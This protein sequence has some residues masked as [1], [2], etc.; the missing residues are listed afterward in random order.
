MTPPMQKGKEPPFYEMGAMPFQELCRDLIAVQA[1]FIDCRIYGDNGEEQKGI[2]V[3]CDRTG[4]DLE[5]AQAKCY[6][7]YSPSEIAKASDK[8]FEYLDYWLAEGVKEFILIV[9]CRISSIKANEQIEIERQRFAQHGIEYELWDAIRIRDILREQH[10]L[11]STHITNAEYWTQEICGAS[12]IPPYSRQGTFG[13]SQINEYLVAKVNNLSSLINSRI[14]GELEENRILWREGRGSNVIEWIKKVKNNSHEW[15]E[16]SPDLQA[17]IIRLEA[18]VNID[19]YENY[20][21][22]QQ[23]IEDAKKIDPD[24]FDLRIR[25]S[26]ELHEH[27]PEAALKIIGDSQDIDSICLRAS[28]HLQLNQIT[29]AISLLEPLLNMQNAEVHRL[30]ALGYLGSNSLEKAVNEIQKAKLIDGRLESIQI[31]DA[32]LLYFSALSP[33][34]LSKTFF[35]WPIPV[36]LDLIKSS[37]DAIQGLEKASE[38]FLRIAQNEHRTKSDRL[39]LFVWYAACLAA[40]FRKQAEAET[41]FRDLLDK[42][43]TDHRLITWIVSR[44]FSANLQK[45][46][47]ELKN[48]SKKGLANTAHLISAVM[49]DIHMRHTRNTLYLLENNK[50]VF[51]EEFSEHLWEHWYIETLIVKN[52][53]VEAEERL[54]ESL[55]QIELEPLKILLLQKQSRITGIDQ[56]FL[57]F[58]LDCVSDG[59]HPLYLL[60]LCNYYAYRQNW[61]QIVEYSVRLVSDIQTCAALKLAAFSLF[62]TGKFQDCKDFI[63]RQRMLCFER[64]LP[65]DLNL[66]YIQSMALIGEFQEALADLRQLTE[67]NPTAQNLVLLRNFYI[68]KGDQAGLRYVA[69][70]AKEAKIKPDDIM[71]FASSVL[72]SSRELAKE[73]WRLAPTD[74]LSPP[75]L[76]EKMMLGIALGLDHEIKDIN[77]LLPDIVGKKG[78]PLQ[79]VTQEE[80]VEII[81]DQNRQKDELFQKYSSGEIPIHVLAKSAGFNLFAFYKNVIRHNSDSSVLASQK[82]PLYVRYGG[83]PSFT[84]YKE[85]DSTFDIDQ[86]SFDITTLLL[87]DHFSLLETLETAVE[88]I[89]IPSGT[90]VALVQMKDELERYQP[91]LVRACKLVS[92]YL[93]EGKIAVIA[94]QPVIKN[95][96][97]SESERLLEFLAGIGNA[98]GFVIGFGS[99]QTAWLGLEQRPDSLNFA[100]C[101][102]LVEN[103]RKN[104][105]ITESE[106][107]A[108]IDRLGSEG[109]YST[110]V[111]IPS[112]SSLYF[113][114]NTITQIA[115][116]ELMRQICNDY[117]IW[118]ENNELLSIRASIKD[119]RDRDGFG[120]K[121][122]TLTDHVSRGLDSKKY[123][124]LPYSKTESN[125]EN[126][127]RNDL[128]LQNLIESINSAQEPK[129]YP[130]VDDLVIQ[131]HLHIRGTQILGIFDLAWWFHKR[132]IISEE[133]YFDLLNDLRRAELRYIPVSSD[134]ILLSLREAKIENRELIEGTK[135]RSLRMSFSA[136]LL[137]GKK[138]QTPLGPFETIESL[139]EFEYLLSMVHGVSQAIIK[140][141]EE[142]IPIEQ[143]IIK[144]EWIVDNLFLDFLTLC[145]TT[146]WERNSEDHTFLVGLSLSSF[147]LHGLQFQYDSNG[148]T[149]RKKYFEW[150]YNVICEPRFKANQELMRVTVSHIK[151]TLSKEISEEGDTGP[152]RIIRALCER[153]YRDLPDP[154]KSLVEEDKKFLHSI[155]VEMINVVQMGDLLFPAETLWNEIADVIF[156][157]S[158]TIAAIQPEANVLFMSKSSEK[159][160]AVTLIHPASK[161]EIPIKSTDFNFLI[162]DHYQAW[163]DENTGSFAEWSRQQLQDQVYQISNLNSPAQRL[164]ALNKLRRASIG[165][166]Y[167]RLEEALAETQTLN[168]NQISPSNLQSLQEFFGVKDGL[169]KTKKV[170]KMLA[171]AA[172]YL[173]SHHNLAAAI[174]RLASLP[175]ELPGFLLDEIRN[176][177]NDD[178]KKL[179]DELHVS[180][181]TPLSRIHL[182]RI[183]VEYPNERE[184]CSQ[185][186]HTFFSEDIKEEINAFRQVLS[187]VL[188]E[189]DSQPESAELSIEE[190]LLLGWGHSSQIFNIFRRLA[191]PLD[192]LGKVFKDRRASLPLRYVFS[193]Q[194]MLWNDVA[195]GGNIGWLSFKISSLSY[196]LKDHKELLLEVEDSLLA[197]IF[198]SIDVLTDRH[199]FN[200]VVSS[201]IGGELLEKLQNLLTKED[202]RLVILNRAAL[203]DLSVTALGWLSDSQSSELH[204]RGW[205]ILLAIYHNQMLPDDLLPVF[206]QAISKFDFQTLVK[207]DSTTGFMS[208]YFST[209]QGK[210]LS[211]DTLNYL[212]TQISELSRIGSTLVYGSENSHQSMRKDEVIAILLDSSIHLAMAATTEPTFEMFSNLVINILD[213]WK[214]AKAMT[215]RLLNRLITEIPIHQAQKL[216]KVL[217]EVRS[218]W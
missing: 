109:Q 53:F 181:N 117:S 154:L 118:V 144:S 194:P 208:L 31:T 10:Q 125:N 148:N 189:I 5:V 23:L 33:A 75:M 217:L 45:S 48:L 122:Q 77:R 188:D 73:L 16:I 60:E 184:R 173:Y 24:T 18:V 149:N 88:N 186:I 79:H 7:K 187:W 142:N 51:V 132:G 69:T 156:G 205:Q 89:R 150:V 200:N 55:F 87:L 63:D 167:Q 160:F 216:G 127:S 58:L 95:V 62:N 83:R 80:A 14:S 76:A 13:V 8:F 157:E 42:H 199:R 155:G 50:K 47:L 21:L 197:E 111:F 64:K 2:D 190:K 177:S 99:R 100:T 192:W 119:E 121:L 193:K 168:F 141:W 70:L 191:V 175:V 131:K 54:A 129:S 123:T 113:I 206:D 32:I 84:D 4:G 209:R 29:V 56:L 207:E 152:G 195:Y 3:R 25:A 43:P 101:A 97:I 135:L 59:N 26:L 92:D 98:N 35:I 91:E 38:I 130:V 39:S 41:Q 198:P 68:Q 212:I 57:D 218:K 37:N 166:S 22:A 94:N 136:S 176:L 74:K 137:F 211:G 138:L 153:L 61:I 106:R 172:R 147:F 145:T 146:G 66:V 196:S 82:F 162:G 27:G 6:E 133:R 11:I 107:L 114:A 210:Y 71:S 128:L 213:N 159:D 81:K 17:N 19:F 1:D 67:N 49:L 171:Q 180:L 20:Q 161:K 120:L 34:V 44:N 105:I 169:K 183:M 179:F 164:D 28:L 134:E 201:F 40:D 36:E 85:P 170:N 12:P 214:D 115:Q 140:I 110:G 108:A 139:G 15:N 9:A 182:I 96:S 174:T 72:W 46:R 215:L 86:I 116:T 52:R 185:L 78:V 203:K 143:R 65:D 93:A 204:V 163:I 30:L 202:D 165:N 102:D 104:G 126:R 178:R 124:F 103:L 112:G 158:K 90:V 151:N